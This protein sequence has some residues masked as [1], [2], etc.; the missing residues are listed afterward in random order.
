MIKI[1][2]LSDTH[3]K[4]KLHQEA[5]SHLLKSGAE[6]F[7]HTGDIGKEEHLMMLE[8]TKKP[9]R[10]VFGN[11]DHNLFSLSSKYQIHKEP[12]YLTIDDIKIKIM[13]LPYF[14]SADTDLVISGHTHYFEAN[15]NG[16]TLYLNSGEICA[17]E[18]NLTECVLL[19]ITDKEWCVNRYFR[20]PT[21][22]EWSSKKY[23]FKRL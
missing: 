18:K 15:L 2:I 4:S 12:Y 5:I 7:L 3:F 13:H 6:Y 14:M 19:E 9:Y 21:I 10:V 17:R 16:D 23:L 22:K 11:N 20:K 1:G 8:A